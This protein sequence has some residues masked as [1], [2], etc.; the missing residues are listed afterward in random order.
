MREAKAL[1]RL[2]V[3][4]G[5]SEFSLLDDSISTYVTCA[6]HRVDFAEFRQSSLIRTFT[7]CHSIS[8]F[9]IILALGK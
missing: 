7:I 5:S 6:G 2:R 8:V 9:L 1:M 4:T 3:R